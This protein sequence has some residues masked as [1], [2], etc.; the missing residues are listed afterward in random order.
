MAS[1]GT[2]TEQQMHFSEPLA[3]TEVSVG[4]R[5]ACSPYDLLLSKEWKEG[6]RLGGS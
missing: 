5:P 3:L 4:E 6:D 2:V 1:I